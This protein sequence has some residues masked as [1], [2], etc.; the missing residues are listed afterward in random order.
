MALD[1]KTLSSI[2]RDYSEGNLERREFLKKAGLLGISAAMSS[3]LAVVYS[4]NAFAQ[5]SREAPQG[6]RSYDYIIVGSGSA[7]SALAYRLATTTDASILV[8]EA[9]G[10]DDVPEI[11]DPRRWAET[12]GTRATKWFMTTEQPHTANRE[13]NWPR[14]NVI[15]GT[16]S[17]N[18]MIFA[19]GHQS[20]FDGWAAAGCEG[21]DYASVLPYFKAFENW[22]GGANAYRAVGGPLSVTR[23][24]ENLRHPGGEMFIEASKALGFTETLDFNAEQM[25]GPAWVNFTIKDQRR[26]STGV[27]FLKPAMARPNLTVLTDSPVT[28]VIVERGRCVGVEYL[29]NGQPTVVR[30]DQEVILSAGSIDTPRILLHSGIG[31]RADLRQV[32]IASVLDLPGVGQNLQDHVLGGGPNYE[33]PTALPESNYNASEVYMW[34]KSDSSVVAPDMITLYLNIPFSTPALPMDGIKNGW[35][36][37]SGLARPT[38]TGSLKLRSNRVTD[39][40]IIDPN[41]LATEHDRRVFSQAT[42]LARETALQSQFASVRA[43]EWLPGDN[44][45]P[46]TPAW[47]DFIAKCAHTYFHPTSTCKMGVDDM[48]VV[49]PQLRVRGISHLRVADASVMPKI[50]TSN[51]NAPSIMIGWKCAEMIRGVA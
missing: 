25:E 20:D 5:S 38:S 51:T 42:E 28:K 46:G 50:T 47:N 33:S 31:P 26:Q 14:G 13:H 22:E 6:R 32:G 30:C 2:I 43:K 10:T 12:L 17:L 27:A 1:K 40:P 37:L 49:D 35:S 15:G 34:A 11:H 48:A 16:S 41:Y 7:G 4:S 36:I 18:A 23:P 39:A 45:R 19:R 3:S 44:V 24:Q 8:L 21:W 9:G 29:H